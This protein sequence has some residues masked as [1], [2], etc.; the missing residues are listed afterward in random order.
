M[1]RSAAGLG[2]PLRLEP[3]SGGLGRAGLAE[4]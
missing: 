3:A 1:N 2:E 4:R